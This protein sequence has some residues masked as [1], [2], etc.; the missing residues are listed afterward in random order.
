MNRRQTPKVFFSSYRPPSSSGGSPTNLRQLLLVAAIIIGGYFLTR[1]PV[2]QITSVEVSGDK[3][4]GVIGSLNELTGTSL[5]SSSVS[6]KIDKIITNNPSILGLTCRK[7]IP[8]TLRCHL[9][10]RQPSFVWRSGA[11]TFLIDQTGLAYQEG[12]QSKLLV[13]EDGESLGVELG[14]QLMSEEVVKVFQDIVSGLKERKITVDR[15]TIATS[16]LHPTAVINI[17]KKPPFTSDKVLIRFSTG[18][19]LNVQFRLFDQF[20]KRQSIKVTSYIDLR[21]PGYIYYK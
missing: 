20:L 18:Y 9:Q 11:K 5:F 10:L 17:G 2:F 15:L 19:P 16:T 14:S 13:I 1:L 3:D 6:L 12:N 7:G 21:T 4:T 8:N